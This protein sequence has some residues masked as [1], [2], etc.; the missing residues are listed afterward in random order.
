MC[1]NIE[2]SSVKTDGTFGP[3][4]DTLI[5][6]EKSDYRVR[7]RFNGNI[8][9]ANHQAGTGTQTRRI[10]MSKQRIAQKFKAW[11]KISGGLAVLTAITFVS[12]MHGYA[13]AQAP[14]TPPLPPVRAGTQPPGTAAKSG[15]V[16]EKQA[17]D[18]LKRMSAALSAAKEFT[19]KSRST[20]EVS[21]RRTGQFITLM[22]NSEVAVQRPNK[23]RVIVKGEVPNFDFYYDGTNIAAY[24]P[25]NKVYSIAKA[26]G[27]IDQM[28]KTL[29]E[30]TGIQFP[31]AD[32]LSGDPYAELTKGLTSAMV[33]GKSTVDG[34]PCEHLAFKS[35]GVHW[36]VWVDAGQSALP[37]RMAVT[38]AD[39]QNFPRRLV[40]FSDWNTQPN[41]TDRDFAFQIPADA[42]QIEFL[43]PA[44]P[45]PT[46]RQKGR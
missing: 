14:P 42:R 29:E 2:I 7:F 15:D 30:K 24:A 23:L 10:N 45:V 3:C 8:E 44:S 38:Y 26:P 19:C 46:G 39:V 18:D 31:A 1:W 25:K 37:Q 16:I 13:Q 20:L 43:S 12:P 21:S 22:G 28:F 17:L 5:P 40:E 32:L 41:L 35:P 33:V 27:T 9:H 34:V 6:V 11:P 36:E 4:V